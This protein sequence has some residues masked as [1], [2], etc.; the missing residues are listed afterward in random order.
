MKKVQDFKVLGYNMLNKDNYI[1]TLKGKEDIPKIRPGNFAE[2]K[3]P[4]SPD[5][6][7]RRPISVLDV[8]YEK[9]TI[10]F[11]IKAVGKGTLKLGQL[12]IG[13][14][15]NIV[16][17]LGNHFVVGKERKVLIVGGGSGIAPFVSLGRELKSK[18]IDTTFLI[19]ARTSEDI[20]L[21]DEFAKYGRVE[22]T[23]EDGSRGEKGLVTAHRGLANALKFDKVYTCGPD[24]MMK[25]VAKIANENSIDCEASLENMM[26][27]GIGACLCC[28]TPTKEGNKVVCAEGPVFNTKDL[29]W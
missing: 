15:V 7:L 23:T 3:V 5:V 19:G 8:D 21:T 12:N 18:K 27:C 20:F 4:D 28:V 16:Y 17:P 29:A 24:P 26:A 2:I 1:L 9:K 6:F 14:K 25:A 13:Q 22:V 11:Y 10:S